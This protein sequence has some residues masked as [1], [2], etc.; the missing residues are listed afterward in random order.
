MKRPILY[1]IMSLVLLGIGSMQLSAQLKV[2]LNLT[3]R[4][5]PYLTNWSKRPD[6]AV[7]TVVNST[8]NVIE[9]KFKCV[10]NKDGKFLAETKN[11]SMVVLSIPPGASQYFGADLVPMAAMRVAEGA[12][13]TAARTGML[14]AGSYQFC[15]SLIDPVTSAVITQPVCKGFSVTSFQAPILL[16]PLD[17][18]GVAQA[19]RPMFRWTGISPRPSFPVT[20]RLQVFEVLPEQTAI[21]A[22][23]A[24]R[25]IMDIGGIGTTQ[26]L[27]PPDVELPRPDMTYVWSVRALNE[28]GQPVGDPDGYATPFMFTSNAVPGGDLGT[29]S[30]KS[31]GTEVQGG[32]NKKSTA[33]GG[34]Q[35]ETGSKKSGGGAP[36]PYV[37]PNPAGLPC[38]QC[39]YPVTIT[40]TTADANPVAVGDS[41]SIG[42][43]TMKVNSLT[44]ATAASAGGKGEITIPWLWAR[45][46]VT[47][48]SLKVNA[49]KQVIKGTARTEV[50][51]AAPQYPQQWAIN[52]AV[53]WNWTKSVV[54]WVDDF[55]KQNGKL[56]KQVNNLSV[57]LKMPLGFNNIKGYTICISEMIF[58]EQDA[59]LAAVA[60]VPLVKL[61]DTLSFG[62]KNLSICPEGVGKT[63]RLELAQDFAISGYQQAT[64]TFT[65]TAAAP[66][67][68]RQ[69]CY[70]TWGCDN[71]SDTL[72]LDIDVA[73]PRTWMT[74]R[75]DV[76]STKRSVATLTGKTINWKEW[77]VTG[78]LTASTFA[79]AN[80]MGLQIDTMAFDFSDLENAPNMTFPPNY[81][82]TQDSTFNGFFAKK[83]K[84]FMPD[85][86]RTFA[87]SNAAPEFIAQ[88]LII[89]KNGFTGDLIAA[90][91]IQFPKANLNRLGASVDTVKV[92]FLN[93]D[94]TQA[95]MRG[96]IQLPVT[97]TLPQNSITYK[98]LFNNVEKSFDF[99]LTPTN[100]IDVK[101]LG[102][103]KLTLQPSSALTMTLKKGRKKFNLLLNG[104][105]GWNS[106]NLQIGQKTVNVDMAPD[107]EN[108]RLFYDDSIGSKMMFDDGDWSFASGQKKL[109]KFPITIDKVK[110]ST[111]TPQGNELVRGKLEFDII[112]ALDS[113]KIGG[114][115]T[116]DL[117]GAI[118]KSD[119]SA[120][121]K[122]KPT[123]VD[124]NVQKIKVWA[125]LAAVKITGELNFYNEDATWGN[126]FAAALDAKFKELQMQITADARFGSKLDNTNTRYRYWYVNAK[127]IL[128]PPGIVF[129]PGYAFY[130][131]GAAA[132]RRVNVNMTG[133]APNVAQVAGATA[134]STTASSGAAM[135]PDKNV[136]F[137]FK[138]LA[139]LGATPD[140]S[141]MNADIALTAQFSGTGGIST[142]A[143]LGDLWLQAKLTERPSAP[144]KGSLSIAYDFTQRIFDLN[145]G[146]IVNKTPVTGNANLWVHLEG[147]TGIWFVKLGE[148]AQR[149]T[150]NVDFLGTNISANSYFMFGK[151]ITPPTGFTTRTY[152]GLA[153]AGCYGMTPPSGGTTAAISGNGFAGGMDLGFDSGERNRKIV[154]RV[155]AK[156]RFAGGFEFNASFLRYP[157]GSL[158]GGDGLNWWYF[159][160]NAAAYAMANASVWIQPKKISDG[161]VVCCTNNH[162]NGCTINLA[163]IKFGAWAEAGFPKKSWIQGQATGSY[164][165]LGGAFKGSFNAE[166]NVGDRC[167]PTPPT[168][169]TTAAQDVAAEQK[170][171][172]IKSVEPANNATGV[173]VTEP[174]KIVYNFEPN[175]AFELTELQGGAAGNTVNRQF[176]VKYDVTI[177]QRVNGVW[178]TLQTVHKKDALGA[179]LYRKKKP[180]VVTSTTVAQAAPKGQSNAPMTV[181]NVTYNLAPAPPAPPVQQAP[182]KVGVGGKNVGGNLPQEPV[183]NELGGSAGISNA[184]V[185]TF[186][187]NSADWDRSTQVRAT[188]V[189]TLWE[190]TG[191]NQWAVAKDRATNQ[192]VKQTIVR[193]FSTPMDPVLANV[194]TNNSGK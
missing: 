163:Q 98:A 180:L 135:S 134:P 117:T 175:A 87:D 136:G 170:N 171:L 193:T 111:P 147:K 50:D 165:V 88:N 72:S 167:T 162:P 118:E 70:V 47:F 148:P 3:Q 13:V 125:D 97:D 95:Y 29:G 122:F 44:T 77:V 101:L 105:M 52:Q 48:D 33:A 120:K 130:G 36:L 182:I 30:K 109:G 143:I 151:N 38:G 107:F 59:A 132:W 41:L 153:S 150:I 139:V 189:G 69:G 80:G 74:P 173:A 73:F 174:V 8:S 184:G 154:G 164:D 43:F 68:Q 155:Y 24:N 149:N 169:T 100:Q 178:T 129:M 75:P 65:I 5:D 121:F 138:V 76:D 116:F 55:V 56:V 19:T 188:V 53:S 145:A 40:D 37:D 79:N 23:R 142:M 166:F 35:E 156:W 4:P 32:N 159:Q 110:F 183:E 10:V 131:F 115:G 124:F 179:V 1:S 85:G 71:N 18:S 60:A 90:N 20:Y 84:M 133:A 168:A 141:K 25:P 45:V 93:N 83:I 15:V 57:P 92:V 190:R 91:V 28:D 160:A 42:R 81:V 127:A 67:A 114:R 106:V 177:E 14:P 78:N 103:A 12:D 191:A 16:L 152:N 63:G 137:G 128:P 64:P 123:F 54:A 158:C 181:N 7:V 21:N 46:L 89:N 51:P 62:A 82:G 86:W 102:G 192:D 2:N 22:F 39:S 119:P 185:D 187:A 172:L 31:G 17:K 99:S 94:I 6:I 96:K 126:G 146:V 104:E 66:T 176:Q 161:C 61:N 144:V 58:T 26:L 9:A 186:I 112:V 113:N 194:N 27:W 49:A 34:G 140:P 108:M 11:E 157:N